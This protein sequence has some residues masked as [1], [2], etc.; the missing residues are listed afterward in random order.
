MSIKIIVFLTL[1]FAVLGSANSSQY[2]WTDENGCSYC[3]YGYFEDGKCVHINRK[4]LLK[5]DF[6]IVSRLNNK[7]FRVSYPYQSA[8]HVYCENEES[9]CNSIK[10]SM[11]VKLMP[12]LKDR[13]SY[14]KKQRKKRQNTGM[15][16]II[17]IRDD[18]VKFLCDFIEFD[19]RKSVLKVM[20]RGS[21]PVRVKGPITP[22]G[23]TLYAFYNL[24][25]TKQKM[26]EVKK[27]IIFT[28]THDGKYIRKKD[29]FALGDCSN[30]NCEILNYIGG[31]PQ[32]FD[33][34]CDFI[35]KNGNEGKVKVFAAGVCPIE[36]LDKDN[37][38]Q[39]YRVR[40]VKDGDGYKLLMTNKRK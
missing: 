39:V 14:C 18:D 3:L 26:Y 4:I 7:S 33:I 9:Y 12:S 17:P 16:Y 36:V 11:V 6:D 23:R 34:K 24:Y 1:L 38:K 40:S 2:E 22:A 32:D 21:C 25:I 5:Y 27:E 13:K 19:Y 31:K 20:G 37:K 28:Q 29:F 35:K 8:L 15:F 30:S 10:D